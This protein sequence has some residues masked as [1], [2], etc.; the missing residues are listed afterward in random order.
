[1]SSPHSAR[2]AQRYGKKGDAPQPSGI[3]GKIL[4]VILIIALV[5]V[6][7]FIARTVQQLSLIHI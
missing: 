5:V 2:P 7:G 1:M 3:G 6:V 4:A